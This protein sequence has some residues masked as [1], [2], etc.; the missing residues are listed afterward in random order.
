MQGLAE[1]DWRAAAAAAAAGEGVFDYTC[2]AAVAE[3][4]GS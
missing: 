1:R 3:G 4:I 2:A